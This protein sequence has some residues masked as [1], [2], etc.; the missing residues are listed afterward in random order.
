MWTD[1]IDLRDFYETSLGHMARRLI[2]Q[3]LRELWPDL[4]G[5]SVL[6]LG[7]ASPYL[8]VFKDEGTQLFLAAPARQGVL[9]WPERGPGLVTLADEAELPFPDRSIDR[10]LIAHVLES[11]EQVAAMMRESWRVLS[12]GGRLMV[13][14]PNRGGIWAHLDR[15]PFGQGRPYSAGQMSRLLR[16]CL[17]TPVQMR[18]ALF[19][20]PSNSRMLL[21]SAPAWENIG[22]RWFPRLGGVL[23]VEATKQI[24]AAAP[25]RAERKRARAYLTAPQGFRR[26]SNP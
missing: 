15:S 14:V 7:F 19:L 11:T 16:E 2:R 21:S 23:L 24:Y 1:V 8:R 12:D 6:G 26:E 3:G 20:P 9:P 18:G 5:L 25:M 4:R 10:I 13:L 22:R 17:F